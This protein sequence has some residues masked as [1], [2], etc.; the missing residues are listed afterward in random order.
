MKK[1]VLLVNLGTPRSPQVKDVFSYLNEFLTDGRVIDIPWLP[2][3]L[4]VRG[5]IVPARVRE[6]SAGY[7]QLWTDEGSPLMKYGKAV[8]SLLQERLGDEYLVKLA[9]RY[10]EL[11]IEDA[12]KTFQ[13]ARCQEIT[14]LPLFPH[15]A[16]ATTGSVHQKIMEELKNLQVIPELHF[17]NSYPTHPKMIEAFAA[18]GRTYSPE[19]YD[20]ILFS[21]HG[22]PERHIRKAD[23]TGRCLTPG[24]CSSPDRPTFCYKAQSVE[25]AHAIAQAL[26]IP[27]ERFSICF[28]SRLGKDPWLQPFTSDVLKKLAEPR[29]QRILV[30]CPAFV[31]DCLE[32][33][34]EI[35]VEYAE[36]FLE[37]GGKQLTLVEGLNT[38]PL[39]IDALEDLVLAQ[40][41][42]KS[43]QT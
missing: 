18:I 35:G 16:S 37:A 13:E 21:F 14:V 20:H 40:Q 10:Q 15:Y 33:T 3:Q 22:L 7:K 4:L 38:H 39:W 12:L 2:R 6:S 30:F 17:I 5:V 19:E 28:Q 42:V 34:I 26:D 24:C 41:P 29:G 9:M 8:E 25:T 31:C 23:D 36:E 43:Y 1:G 27:E 32:T 11:P